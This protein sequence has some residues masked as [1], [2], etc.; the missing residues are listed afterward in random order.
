LGFRKETPRESVVTLEYFNQ[1]APLIGRQGNK[2]FAAE[3]LRE[4]RR[5]GVPVVLDTK[6]VESLGQ[7][8]PDT[9]IPEELYE[10]VAK[11]MLKLRLI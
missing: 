7:L 4:A 5:Y 2:A 9:E 6:L 3:I 1:Q 11:Y 8:Q 10:P